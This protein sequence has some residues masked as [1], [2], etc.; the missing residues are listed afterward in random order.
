M[1]TRERIESN[2]V[3]KIVDHY[4]MMERDT[5]E[6]R[7]KILQQL[8]ITYRQVI[9]QQLN[10]YGCQKLATGPDQESL[11]FLEAK[12][13]KDADGITKT[14]QRELT[15]KVNS[16]Y[17]AN[18]RGNR[19]YYLRALDAWIAQRN[20][21]KIPSIS[22]NTLTAAR[23]YAQT[24][25]VREN[26]IQGKWI[27]TGPPPV[28]KVCIRIKALGAVT[29]ETTQKRRL[30]AHVSCPHRWSQLVPKKIECGDN[31]WTG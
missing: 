14:Y 26:G 12:A 13:T 24:R 9:A 30:P 1:T 27:F 11:L 28:C 10:L 21:Y 22:L 29:F 4:S 23:E 2:L 15:N 3:R 18:R 16:L 31:T 17:Q 5:E 7:Q 19:F 8:T 20:L 25:F 6:L